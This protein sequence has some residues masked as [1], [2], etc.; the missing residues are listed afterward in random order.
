MSF[1]ELRQIPFP[2]SDGVPANMLT[3]RPDVRAAEMELLASKADVMA[4]KAAFYPS[5]VLGAGG[6]FNSFDLGKWFT[7]P[8]SL[9]YDLAAGITAP[10][11]QR[12]QIRSMWNEARASQRIAL[13]QYHETAL[14]AYTEVLD[15]YCAG[16]N[17]VERVRLKEVETVAHQRSSPM[18][19]N[20]SN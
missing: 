19:M 15:L 7:A 11:F 12:N 9:V 6:G 3:L 10:V 14:K 18:P 1:E 20:F 8:A 5:L 4:A 17:Q 16:L 13:S 2:L